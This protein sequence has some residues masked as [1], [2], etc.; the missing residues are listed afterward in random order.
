M[1][2]TNENQLPEGVEPPPPGVKFAGTVR[3]MMLVAALLGAGFTL[4]LAA[5]WIGGA[6]RAEAH[7][8]CPMHPTVVSDRPGECPICGMDLVPIEDA[9]GGYADGAHA[10]H[11]HGAHVSDSDEAEQIREVARTLGAKPGQWVCPMP[12]DGVVQDEPGRCETCG[13]RLVQVP[14]EAATAA[15]GKGA[16]PAPQPG[17][18]GA[19][20]PKDGAGA[21]GATPIEGSQGLAVAASHGPRLYSCPMHPEVEHEGPGKC[22]ICGM[23]L[24]PRDD[25][26]GGPRGIPGLLEVMIPRERLARIGVRTAKVER[27]RLEEQVRTV[28]VVTADERARYVVQARFSGWIEELLVDETG[29]VVKAGQPLL[30]VYSPELYQ[31]QVEYLNGIKWGTE[32]AEAGAARLRLL[33]V[34][35]EEITALRKAGKPRR[36]MTIRAPGAGHVLRKEAVA[37]AYVSPGDVL[38]EVAD[39]SR[40]WVL[41]DVF[42]QEIPRVQVGAN[43][44]FAAP[45]RPAERFVG[46]VSFVY[47]T[48]EP[49]T[50]TMKVRLEI[51]NAETHLRPGMFGDVRLEVAAPEGM[52]VPRDAVIDSGDHVYALV[53]LGEG[54]FAPKEVHVTG[55]AGEH[56]M[57]IGLDEGEEVVTSAGFFIDAESR[58]RAALDGL[59]AGA[60]NG[61]HHGGHH[62][63]HE[64]SPAGG[65]DHGAGA[66]DHADHAHAAEGPGGRK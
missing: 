7:Y 60:A 39:L 10:H 46:R 61:G 34:G 13:M 2:D 11:G 52:I 32:L 22:P 26:A 5:G 58:L 65:H 3:W 19:S 37:G 48:V 54:R 14:P 8:H 51:P 66:H 21:P 17:Q 25:L 64:V 16:A 42:E 45:A 6:A 56:V 43:A 63:G 23:Y 36:A 15:P 59:G 50:R 1:N 20:S 28:G 24:V 29:P 55:R 30:R 47:P 33:G 4:S 57:V 53:A 44:T 27:G 12:E 41:A 9:G 18:G 62:G 31:A 35:P 38:F 40:V 49:S